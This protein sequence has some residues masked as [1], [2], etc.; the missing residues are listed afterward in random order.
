M[1]DV[2]QGKILASDHCS[3]HTDS[4]YRCEICHNIILHPTLTLLDNDWHILCPH[5]AERGI[6]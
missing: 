6:R 1:T 5:C 4:I 2:K 3:Q